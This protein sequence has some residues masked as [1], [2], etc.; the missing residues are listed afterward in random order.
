MI[1]FGMNGQRGQ[2]LLNSLNRY[3][4]ILKIILQLINIFSNDNL[5]QIIF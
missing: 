5:H 2:K 1:I 3:L 4:E